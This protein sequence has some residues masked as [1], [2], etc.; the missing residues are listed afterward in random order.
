MRTDNGSPVDRL[1][2]L[3]LVLST[4][5]TLVSSVLYAARGWDDGVAAV[6]HILGGI[7][8]MLAV[9]RLVTYLIDLPVL[10]AVVLA[11]GMLG[12]GGV[13]GYGFNT[14]G[15]SLGAVDLVDATGPAAIIRPLGLCWPLAV[16]LI[17][18]G[19]MRAR[20]VPTVIGLG[21]VLAGVVYPV[22]RIGNIA[23]L[24][25]VVDV[26][27]LACLAAVTVLAADSATRS[28]RLRD[29]DSGLSREE[30]RVPNA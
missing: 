24:A 21:L 10:A 6:F 16:I 26:V 28:P 1:L 30:V 20:R 12:C 14:I 2:T 22:S 4:A 8:G 23:W 17:G 29:G 5:L 7:V 13:V 15:V 25:I 18:V 3:S 27:L 19:L 11:V 9:V